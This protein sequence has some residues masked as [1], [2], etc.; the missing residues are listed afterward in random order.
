MAGRSRARAELGMLTLPC[1]GS[2]LYRRLRLPLIE[3]DGQRPAAVLADLR[4]PLTDGVQGAAGLLD[5]HRRPASTAS[6]AWRRASSAVLGDGTI[7][8]NPEVSHREL[9]PQSPPGG[10]TR[11]PPENFSPGGPPNQLSND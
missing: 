11:K 7:E 8:I 1:P 6:Q 10:A 3:Q 4:D 9:L 5:V 2:T